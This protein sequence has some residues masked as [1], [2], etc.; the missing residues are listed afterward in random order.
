MS[1]TLIR[2]KLVEIVRSVTG[3]ENVYDYPITFTTWD[4]FISHFKDSTGKILGFEIARRAAKEN[5]DD[6]DEATCTHGYIIKGYMGINNAGAS[7]KAFQSLLEAIRDRFRFDHGLSG[8][9]LDA[10]GNKV[11]EATNV[12]PVQVERSDERLF[13]SVLC[14]YAEMAI[15]VSELITR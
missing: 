3:A 12:T 7:D 11:M 2:A 8:V 6:P 4:D 5:Y 13:G 14:H 9:D 10:Q 1:E 15:S